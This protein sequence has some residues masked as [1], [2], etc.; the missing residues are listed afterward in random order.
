M[1]VTG[2]LYVL[3]KG[4]ECLS[5]APYFA[6]FNTYVCVEF[7]EEDQ[8]RISR[9]AMRSCLKRGR[10]AVLAKYIKFSGME[11]KLAVSLSEVTRKHYD[12]MNELLP[13]SFIN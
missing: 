3:H 2:P 11:K 5:D 12:Q 10:R 1:L 9:G 7:E 4:R 13:V 8:S 6:F